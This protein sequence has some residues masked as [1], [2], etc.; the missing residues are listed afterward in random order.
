MHEAG[1]GADSPTRAP[2]GRSGSPKKSAIKINQPAF[3]RIELS[4]YICRNMQSQKNYKNNGRETTKILSANY[5]A[6]GRR[7]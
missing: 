1:D 7:D 2:K 3:G 4:L 6:F 5:A